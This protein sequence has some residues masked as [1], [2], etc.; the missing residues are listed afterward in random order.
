MARGVVVA[1]V[2]LGV[3]LAGHAYV[4]GSL[5]MAPIGGLV[6]LAVAVGC[7]LAAREVWTPLRLLL[8]LATMQ[9]AVHGSMWLAGPAGQV[10]PRLARFVTDVGPTHAHTGPGATSAGMVAAHLVAIVVAAVLLAGLDATGELLRALAR[11]V[12]RLWSGPPLPLGAACGLVPSHRV[13]TTAS[14]LLA[15]ATSRRGPPALVASR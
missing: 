7:V 3:A 14:V 2:G 12:R 1:T 9:V 11:V 10:D 4:G 15:P 5:A 13:P 8:A 6:A